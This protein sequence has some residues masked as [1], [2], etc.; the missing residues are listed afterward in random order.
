MTYYPN[1][2][3]LRESEVRAL[4][5]AAGQTFSHRSRYRGVTGIRI[6]E[7]KKTGFYFIIGPRK[8]W[9]S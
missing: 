2:L 7:P 9:V 8:T 4:E 3:T 1:F 6:V 5:N